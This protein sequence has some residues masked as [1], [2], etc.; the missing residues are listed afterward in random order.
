MERDPSGADGQ[1][2]DRQQEPQAYD[3]G[4]YWQPEGQQAEG[5]AQTAQPAQGQDAYGRPAYE[6]AGYGQDAYGQPGYPAYPAAYS[7]QPSYAEQPYPDQSYPQQSYPQESYPQQPY[8]GQQQSYSGQPYPDQSYP[9]GSYGEPGY[10]SG[11]AQTVE[12]TAQWSS[13]PMYQQDVY[14]SQGYQAD[15][16]A[17]A[18]PEPFAEPPA[19]QAEQADQTEAVAAAA[20]PPAD[21]DAAGSQARSRRGRGGPDQQQSP[22]VP[23]GPLLPRLVAAATGRA[24]GT[25]RRTFL[26]RAAIGA[27]ALAVVAVAG[28]AVAGS[29]GSTVKKPAAGAPAQANLGSGHTKTWAAPAAVTASGTSD[30]LVG[31]WILPKAVVR[32][33]GMAVTAYDPT[34]GHKLW[35]VIPPAAGAVPCAMSPTVN[36]TGVGAVLFQAKAG[37]GQA[38]TQLVTVDTATGQQKWT[39]KIATA[40]TSFGASV[41]VNDSRAVAVG[42]SA[43][44]GYDIA[45]GKQSWTY[46]GPGKFCALAGNGTGSTLL[47]QSTCAD[48]SPK[49]QAI[50][51][52]VATGKLA[53]WR[54]LPQ[55]AASYTVLSASPA[56]VSVHMT[57]PTKD[58]IMSFSDKGDTQASI[59]VSQTAGQLDSTHGSFDPV[60]ALFFQGGTVVA[61]LNPVNGS[62]S[63]AG[64]L[65]AFNLVDGH[66]LW[67]ATPKEKGRSALVGIDGTA[68]VVATEERLGQ[69]ARLGHYDLATGNESVGG[70]FPQGT[71]SLLT[72]GRVLYQSNVVAVLP[73][74]TSTYNTS[75]TLFSATG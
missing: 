13:A 18:A 30:G 59:F 15:P 25:D 45:S 34:D 28:V 40:S 61:E 47:V 53:W 33:D 26:I 19:E 3:Y 60:P 69:P 7:D 21:S 31:S 14:G 42:D 10:Y 73:E 58:S 44:V 29:G 39:A 35:S 41:M 67:Q 37:S 50:S 8:P 4:Q 12:A 43:A 75:A 72:S 71:G 17:P 70:N 57:D 49:Q 6:Q 51:L 68:A 20:P 65:T 27:A 32:G 56:V 11:P 66:Q 54:G 1:H 38:C 5:Y 55:N 62:S 64:V 46:G 24:P 16:Y 48:T 22:H 36:T 9:A 2:A 52:D 74:F 63:T 23:D